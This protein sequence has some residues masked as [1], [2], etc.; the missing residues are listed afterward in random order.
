MVKNLEQW[1]GLHWTVVR[2][3]IEAN[4][5]PINGLMASAKLMQ[6]WL[7]RKAIELGDE[8]PSPNMPGGAAAMNALLIQDSPLCC[9][10][11]DAVMGRI[12]AESVLPPE[13]RHL[14]PQEGHAMHLRDSNV[15]SAEEEQFRRLY[16]SRFR[17]TG[18]GPETTVHAPCPMCA[19]DDFMVYPLAGV[20]QIM[21]RDVTCP[22]CRRTLRL[23]TSDKDGEVVVE[24]VQVDGPA[25]PRWMAEPPRRVGR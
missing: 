17:T 9:Y 7:T 3:S 18:A 1:C 12:F 8:L 22:G 23:E 10:L 14:S 25:A 11:G 19:F 2:Q 13:Y 16:A 24:L 4:V 15:G 6:E 21:D 5:V 20:A